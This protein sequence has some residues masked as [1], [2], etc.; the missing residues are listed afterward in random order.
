MKMLA[1]RLRPQ[2]LNEMGGQAAS[3]KDKAFRFDP[4]KVGWSLN[5]PAQR[6]ERHQ[7]PAS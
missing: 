7:S 5:S 6:S 2:V 3:V 1:L 4:K